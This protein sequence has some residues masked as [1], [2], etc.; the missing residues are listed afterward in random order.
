MNK[1]T[2]DGPWEY[3]PLSA[4][5]Y[6]GYTFLFIIPIIGWLF[7][8]IF[9]F[10]SKNINRRNYARS[11]WCFLLLLVIGLALTFGLPALSSI[12]LPKNIGVSN[13]MDSIRKPDA[14][15]MPENEPN[16]TVAPTPEPKESES[17]S[18]NGLDPEF[19]AAMDSYEAFFDQYIEFMQKYMKSDNVASMMV[20]YANYMIQYADTMEKMD[21]IDEDNLSAADEAYYVKVHARILKKLAKVM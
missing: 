15:A 13:M 7:L 17:K 8:I 6:V 5:A 20:D 18:S 12:Q 1:Y 4:W 21:K 16:P 10:S 11:Y 14:S 19:K 3:R 9:T 2:Y